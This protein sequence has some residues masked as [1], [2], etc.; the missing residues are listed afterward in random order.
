[1]AE[2]FIQWKMQLK[3]KVLTTEGRKI[4]KIRIIM[5]A[6]ESIVLEKVCVKI[7][8]TL[9]SFNN[10]KRIS[11]K[12]KITMETLLGYNKASRSDSLIKNKRLLLNK[13][14]GP[15]RLPTKTRKYCVLTS[16]HVNKTARDHF[17]IRIHKRIIDILNPTWITY[18][19]L[20]E[21]SVTAGIDINIKRFETDK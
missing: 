9:T 21:L 5:K 7:L 1:V 6:Y 20:T 10:K 8:E 13:I 4:E 14:I 2:K 16:P 19:K 15:I 11:V 3:E 18:Q 17:E 12:D